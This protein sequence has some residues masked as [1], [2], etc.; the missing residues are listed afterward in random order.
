MNEKRISEHYTDENVVRIIACQVTII[1]IVILLTFWA[2]L[3]LLLITDFAIRA[4]TSQPSI[5]TVIAKAGTKQLK[6]TP[7]PIFAAPK[8]FAAALG[9]AFTLT[10]TVLFLLKF[11]IAAYIVSGVLI[12]CAILESV[13]KICVGCYVFDSLVA[14]VINRISDKNRKAA[15]KEND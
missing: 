6:L 10:A 15:D 13:F 7:R 3:V 5:L 12:G 1:S 4:F 11:T 2:W 8:K 9:F 14:P